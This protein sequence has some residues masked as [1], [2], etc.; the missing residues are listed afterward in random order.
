MSEQRLDKTC[1]F[2]AITA[3]NVDEMARAYVE[4]ELSPAHSTNVALHFDQ[5]NLKEAFERRCKVLAMIANSFEKLKLNPDF[6]DRV[7]HRLN[8]RALVK[9]E[10]ES[11]GLKMT[12]EEVSAMNLGTSHVRE[13]QD[14]IVAPSASLNNVALPA[15]SSNRSLARLGAAPWWLVSCALHLLIIALAGLITMS[16]EPPK[17]DDSIIMLTELLSRPAISEEHQDSA[18]QKADNALAS[19]RDTPATDQTSSDL[20]EIVVPPD[21]LAKAE[22]GDHF[23]T[24]NPDL[25][26]THSALGN[27]DS[28]MFHSVQ[29]NTE[30]EGGGGMGGLGMD[31]LIGVGGVPSKGTG[32][33]WG[34]GDGTGV[35]VGT[36][37]GRGSF[38]QRSGGGRK[39]MVKRHGGSKATENA[40]DKALEWLAY[41]QEADGH[42]DSIKYGAM[43]GKVDTAMTSLALLAFLGAGHTEKVGQYKDNVLRAV[44]WLENQQQANGLVYNK[45][46]AQCSGT[47]GYSAAMATMGLSE[48]AGMANVKAT[49]EAAQKAVTYCVDV[50]QNGDGSEKRAWRYEAKSPNEDISNSGW[51]VM[52]LKS[53]K[54]AGLHVDPASFEGAIKYIDSLEI[55]NAGPDTGYG[56]ASRF[57]Y[58]LPDTIVCR[59]RDSAIGV[60]CRQFLGWKKEDLQSSVE[61]YVQDGGTPSDKKVDLYYWYY[62]TLSVFQQG[63]DLWKRWNEDMKGALLPTQCKDGDDTGSWTPAGDFSKNWG[64][65]GQT[66]LSALS[67][68]VYYRYLQLAGK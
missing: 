66:A 2:V 3:V 29:G 46:D 47:L 65:V 25:P 11:R 38:G 23:E 6:E 12:S 26:D 45:T 60:L 33:G 17:N 1:N 44:G 34:G 52:A 14:V 9:A 56:P 35:G 40:V 39:L 18:K 15:E 43:A 22:F 48:A 7:N 27:P 32:G 51:F 68:E 54:V 59:H 36:G 67:L 49:R 55:K 64:R 13:T 61:L 42:W 31:D 50:H 5:P 24:I 30:P 4:G 53:A 62:G 20:S 28:R 10:G 16:I 21:I 41:H 8:I 63:G 57:K 58:S 19:S 37:S